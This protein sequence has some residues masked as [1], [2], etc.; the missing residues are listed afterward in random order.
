M[1]EKLNIPHEHA[2][3]YFD[4]DGTRKTHTATLV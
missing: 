1:A 3:A 2:D 4:V